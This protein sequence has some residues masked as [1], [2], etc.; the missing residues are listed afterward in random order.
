MSK[1]ALLCPT[2]TTEVASV[3]ADLDTRCG[4][5][6]ASGDQLLPGGQTGS[7]DAAPALREDGGSPADV[8]VRPA[9]RRAGSSSARS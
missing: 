4:E 3:T 2:S 6:Y 9:L 5:L 1:S 8:S 7:D